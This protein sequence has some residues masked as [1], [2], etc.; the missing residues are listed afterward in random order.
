VIDDD[1]LLQLFP[2]LEEV[3]RVRTPAERVEA[4]I[5]GF[6]TRMDVD[7]AGHDPQNLVQSLQNFLSLGIKVGTDAYKSDT[8][9]QVFARTADRLRA[10]FA[11]APNLHN[12]P[13]AKA[14]ARRLQAGTLTPESE[15]QSLTDNPTLAA[16]LMEVGLNLADR[17]QLLARASAPQ[18][19]AEVAAA[20]A[21]DAHS[22]AVALNAR[23]RKELPVITPLVAQVAEDLG[24]HLHDERH[25]VRS[26]ASL[27]EQLIAP[28]TTRTLT[29]SGRVHN[30]LRYVMVFPE[31]RFTDDSRTALHG[32]QRAGLLKT[33]VRNYFLQQAPIFRGVSAVLSTE[34]GFTFAVQFHTPASYHA[35]C[36]TH[37]TRKN[38]QRQLRSPHP[39][40]LELQN[41]QRSL[42]DRYDAG[43]VP[44]PKDVH[45][46]Y[47]LTPLADNT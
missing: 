24:A 31:E 46:I 10:L 26:V 32:L 11:R 39:D 19:P 40:P 34:D 42:Q 2:A 21:T 44:V 1:A 15:R 12:A 3:N 38:I 23:A 33:Q 14:G 30:A 45:L 5:D 47:D 36:D 16:S 20:R 7:P 37:D 25:Q 43:K 6:P 17:H 13:Y 9:A 35:K 4:I 28:A 18:E 27:Y 41:Y 8:G 29:T 22:L